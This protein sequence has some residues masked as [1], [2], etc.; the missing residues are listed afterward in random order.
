MNAL[1]E[2]LQQPVRDL[3]RLLGELGGDLATLLRPGPRLVDQAE[4]ICSVL[5]AVALAQLVGAKN[6]GWAAFSGYMVI[7][8]HFSASLQRALLRV[9]GTLTGAIAGYVVAL[10]VAGH[11]LWACVALAV[12]VTC[13]MYRV[14]VSRRTYAWLFTGLTF[15][16]VV[17]ETIGP[18][19]LPPRA[20]ALSRVTEI[21]VGTTASLLVSYLS[22]KTLRRW[23]PGQP[24]RPAPSYRGWQPAA[25]RHAA[26]AG[27]AVACVP[28][29]TAWIA[30][31]TLSQAGVTVMAVMAVPLASL[32]AS[33]R[34]I[35]TRMVHRFVGCSLGGLLA[36]AILLASHHHAA[37][38]TLGL[39]LGVAIGRHIENGPHAYGYVGVQFALAFLVVLVPDDYA[40]A[41]FAP[42]VER[43]AGI[44]AGFVLLIVIRLVF[45]ALHGQH[46]PAAPTPKDRR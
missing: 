31:P 28:L 37:L 11:P 8:S 17:V 27:I 25:A 46:P 5:L 42:G 45:R 44:L 13:T 23:M 10:K 6:V 34:T 32:S 22:A 30:T 16:M 26:Q 29:F 33:S 38:I 19:E 35:S 24:P 41:S 1:T 36:M 39:C 14:L 40:N 3:L 4:A 43:L 15:L 21:L 20:F 18:H 7:R 12:V 9:L 2:R